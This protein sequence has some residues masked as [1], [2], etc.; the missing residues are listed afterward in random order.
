MLQ[1]LVEMRGDVDGFLAGGGVEHEQNFLRLDQVA[2]A[3]QF[4]HQRLV[5]L[6]PAGGV[7]NQHVAVVRS[8]EI[9][10]FAGDFQNVRLAAFDENRHF[11]LFAERFQLVH[12]RRAIN[13]RRH[14]QRLA[15][16]LLQQP[17]ELAAGSGFAGAVQ[18]DHQDASRIAAEIQRRRCASRA[19]PPVRRG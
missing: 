16:L 2:Q 11:N 6:Q 12:G 9:Q 10:R 17:R 14:E 15:A 3:D 19:G 13:V 4:L 8:G 18:T 5:N 7:E 1:R